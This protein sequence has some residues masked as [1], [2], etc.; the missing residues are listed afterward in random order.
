MF[1]FF[2]DDGTVPKLCN[3]VGYSDSWT[4]G[5]CTFSILYMKVSFKIFE[6]NGFNTFHAL[7]TRDSE[8]FFGRLYIHNTGQLIYTGMKCECYLNI[9]ELFNLFRYLKHLFLLLAVKNQSYELSI[10]SYTQWIRSSKV[11]FTGEPNLESI[12][13]TCP[14]ILSGT[15]PTKVYSYIVNFIEK[16]MYPRLLP[17]LWFTLHKYYHQHWITYHNV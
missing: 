1:R 4:D 15:F 14:L 9:Y 12:K 11:N 10:N 3:S 7:W 17:P 13:S 16:L 6:N 5:R 8:V 2:G